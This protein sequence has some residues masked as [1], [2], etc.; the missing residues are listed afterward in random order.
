MSKLPAIN[1]IR[2][3]TGNSAESGLPNDII[4]KISKSKE[5]NN[6]IKQTVGLMEQSGGAVKP[7]EKETIEEFI[8]RLG[9]YVMRTHIQNLNKV[10]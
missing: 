8:K 7:A 4:E 6:L 3:Y 2:Y 5:H 1:V 9:G 10:A